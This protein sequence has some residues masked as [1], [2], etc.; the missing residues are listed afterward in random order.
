MNAL[1]NVI[2][3][4]QEPK[5]T[6]SVKGEAEVSLMVDEIVIHASIESRANAYCVLHYTHCP[7]I[8]P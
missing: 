5:P 8:Y 6:I 3:I 1:L 2:A 4:G 7:W